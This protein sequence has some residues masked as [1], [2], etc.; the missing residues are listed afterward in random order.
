M[1][2]VAHRGASAAEQENTP[3]AFRA[4]DRLGADAVELD[5]RLAPTRSGGQRLVVHHDP[6]PDDTEFVD[7]LPSF[8]EV[9]EACGERMLV[10]VEIK[11]SELEGGHD[12]TMAMVAPTIAAMRRVDGG[13]PGRWLVSSFSPETVAYVR[14]VAP[15]I[16]TALLC[17]PLD[18][19]T[20]DAA[21]QAGHRAV[22]PYGPLVDEAG[23]EVAHRAG[24]AVT[25]WTINEPETIAEL[26]SMGVDGVC[27][28]VPDVAHAVLGRSGVAD[29]APQWPRYS[30]PG[31]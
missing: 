2:I 22:H 18:A 30:A 16:A 26:R 1:I 8:D 5:V 10:N 6:L 23:V 24:L 27:T 28:D 13:D 20:I 19:A 12:P 29:P 17:Y 11:N 21:R 15:E 7:A 25:P 9:L 14:L 3:A 4:A 31:S